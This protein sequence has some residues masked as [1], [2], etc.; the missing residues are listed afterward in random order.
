MLSDV[1]LMQTADNDLLRRDD[2]GISINK[3]PVTVKDRAVFVGSV[4]EDNT[5][6]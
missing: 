3:E 2:R 1:A 4:V 5:K 6:S